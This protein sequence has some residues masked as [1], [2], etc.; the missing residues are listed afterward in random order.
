MATYISNTFANKLMRFFSTMVIKNDS[1]AEFYETVDSKERARYYI[2]AM[3]QTD[4]FYLYEKLF[5]EEDLLRV[6]VPELRVEF[7]LNNLYQ[8]E[9]SVKERLVINK[10]TEIIDKYYETNLY[11]LM[12]NGQPP[13]GVEPYTIKGIKVTDLTLKQVIYEF[14]KEIKELQAKHTKPEDQYLKF[15]GENKI[16]FYTARTTANLRPIYYHKYMFDQYITRKIIDTYYETMSYIQTVFYCK[17]FTDYERYTNF[18]IVTVIFNCINK[19]LSEPVRMSIRGEFD[20]IEALRD[21]FLTYNL[22]FDPLVSK[23]Y[24][25]RIIKN[26]NNLFS[27]KGTNQVL[28]DIVNLFGY[29]TITINKYYLIKSIKKDDDGNFIFNGHP[30]KKYE[31]NF[32]EIPILSSSNGNVV[33]EDTKKN[34]LFSQSRVAL[35][36]DLVTIDDPYWGGADRENNKRQL[37]ETEFNYL[38]TKYLSINTMTN[39]TQI[40]QE[41][42]Y[43]INFLNSAKEEN[44]LDELKIVNTEIKPSSL[45]MNLFDIIVAMQVLIYSK[46]AYEDLIIYSSTAISSLYGF[47]FKGNEETLSNILNKY[48]KDY[49]SKSIFGKLLSNDNLKGKYE[50][51]ELIDIFFKNMDYK[52][53][54][55]DMMF[56]CNDI[57]EYRMLEEIYNYNC[58]STACL[59][60][61]K[62][63]DGTHYLTYSDYLEDVDFE[64]H[65][66]VKEYIKNDDHFSG[67]QKLFDTVDL[68]LEDERLTKM[69]LNSSVSDRLKNYIF[70]L[71]NYFKAYTVDIKDFNVFYL[72][73][74]KSTNCLKFID[75]IYRSFRKID[76]TDKI[77]LDYIEKLEIYKEVFYKDDFLSI[78]KDV[79]YVMKKDIVN[80]Y[81]IFK[82]DDYEIFKNQYITYSLDIFDNIMNIYKEKNEQ[83]GL[84]KEY[85]IFIRNMFEKRHVIINDM[86][87][88]I[89][90]YDLKIDTLEV[91]DLF[92]ERIKIHFSNLDCREEIIKSKSIE[93]K[94]LLSDKI[95]QEKIMYVADDLGLTDYFLN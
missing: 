77:F 86:V 6:G 84:D 59:D 29:S 58:Y 67:I 90:K 22:P 78:M 24:L 72:M 50:R 23:R 39:V 85:L 57:H 21:I 79:Y 1:L 33:N 88:Y 46:L 18:L 26:I 2:A 61:F 48:K 7:F 63:P 80:E 15:L 35:D 8:L 17:S 14:P 5:N 81:S 28:I 37:L 16:D 76:L 49:K 95:K 89:Y 69:F 53:D 27:Y 10:R 3:Q 74:S 71:L 60:M 92:Y 70:Q 38:N 93:N 54:L 83:L 65:N 64:L 36:Y 87:N 44:Y 52:T 43:F 55:E 91:D 11:Y 45:P 42:C 47:N 20:D 94:I 68:Y 56:Q 30:Y 75:E 82:K 19:L 31:L 41:M 25:Q 51:K 40:I 66:F 12:L 62:K 13:I 34:N 9:E 73:G 4:N 32:L